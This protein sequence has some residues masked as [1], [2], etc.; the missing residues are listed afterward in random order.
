MPASSSIKST[1]QSNIDVQRLL[2]K[3]KYL[4]ALKLDRVNYL[5]KPQVMAHLQE[6][7]LLDYFKLPVDQNGDY[8][9]QKDKLL[10]AWL[11]ATIS[12]TILLHVTTY[13]T[14]FD[15]WSVLGKIFNA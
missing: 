2:V 1:T 7:D 9:A 5:S 12:P 6:Y 8:W 4:G 10:L 3:I 15:V 13:G 11:F 14:L